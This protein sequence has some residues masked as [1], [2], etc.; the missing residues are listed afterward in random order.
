VLAL[1]PLSQGCG[2]GL[3]LVHAVL[4]A[5]DALDESLVAFL[6]DPRYY[7]GSASGWG[8]NTASFRRCRT[9]VHISRCARSRP[10]HAPCRA[11]SP[12]PNPLIESDAT[13]AAAATRLL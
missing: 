8:R 6:G 4:G 11:G 2:V 10:S 3:A 7:A 1:G 13:A 12:I 9:G 5:A